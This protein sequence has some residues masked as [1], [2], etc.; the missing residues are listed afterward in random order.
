MPK[1]PKIL[2]DNVRP[3]D[4]VSILLSM[5]RGVVQ[6]QED[7]ESKARERGVMAVQSLFRSVYRLEDLG[8]IK[9]DDNQ[10]VSL[11]EFGARVKNGKSV[12]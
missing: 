7:L 5:R 1:G 9:S 6:N 10:G 8:I 12:V 3:E 11:T 2:V 4:C